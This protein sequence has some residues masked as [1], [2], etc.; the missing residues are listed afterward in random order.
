M[1]GTSKATSWWNDLWGV[2][3]SRCE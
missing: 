3:G 2:R 1:S